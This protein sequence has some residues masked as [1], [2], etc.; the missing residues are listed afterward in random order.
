MASLLFQKIHSK[1]EKTGLE[2]RTM[3]SK[4]WFFQNLKD[5]RSVVTT[6]K[7]LNDSKLIIKNRPLIG[8][9]FQ[10]VYDPKGKKE[11]PFYDTFPLIIMVGPAPGGCYGLN[12][13]YLRPQDRAIFFDKLLDYSSNKTFDENTRIRLKY[14]MLSSTAK[15]RAFQPCFKHYLYSHIKSKTVEIPPSEWEIALFL[16]SDHFAK[17]T[18]ETIWR[19]TRK[20]V[21]EN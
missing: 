8:R 11:L 7:I 16:P 15:L 1:F 12:L 17:E 10:F 2:A 4:K 6:K 21:S 13:H 20:L 14:A 9:V 3:Q 5:M 19:R 18:K